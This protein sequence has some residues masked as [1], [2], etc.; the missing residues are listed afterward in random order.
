MSLLSDK[1]KER[2]PWLGTDE[3]HITG[4]DTITELCELYHFEIN[5]PETF[6]VDNLIIDWDLFREQKQI[7][8]DSSFK[9]ESLREAAEGILSLM[10]VIQDFAIDSGQFTKEEVDGPA[11]DQNE[12]PSIQF[13]EKTF[14]QIG[15]GKCDAKAGEWKVFNDGKSGFVAKCSNCGHISKL[16]PDIM[17]TKPDD[18]KLLSKEIIHKNNLEKGTKNFTFKV[19]L[20]GVGKTAKE[21]W[22]DAIEGFTC[23]PGIM[24]PSSI[25][26]VEE[27]VED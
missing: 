1:L 5:K 10:D 3:E 18:E 2:F 26:L 20:G 12:H 9:M 16:P 4:S 21:A 8:S 22:N 15:C 25:E 24:E 23:E 13:Q 6:Y 19:F 14:W 17:R 11:V 7:L 27:I